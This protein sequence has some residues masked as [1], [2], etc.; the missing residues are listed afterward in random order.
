MAGRCDLGIDK[1]VQL[2][3]QLAFVACGEAVKFGCLRVETQ[4]KNVVV[5]VHHILVNQDGVVVE[6]KALEKVYCVVL[7]AFILSLLGLEMHNGKINGL[8]VPLDR[9]SSVRLCLEGVLVIASNEDNCQGI[10]NKF[11]EFLMCSFL[12]TCKDHQLLPQISVRFI[13]CKYLRAINARV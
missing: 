3:V 8:I 11:K 6:D 2:V 7:T 13:K 10:V 5:S 12:D 9:L 4:G 1:Q